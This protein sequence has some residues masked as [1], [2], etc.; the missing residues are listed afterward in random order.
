[1]PLG[2]VSEAGADLSEVI[3]AQFPLWVDLGIRSDRVLFGGYFQYGPALLGS[4]FNDLCEDAEEKAES[5]GPGNDVSCSGRDIRLGLQLQHHFG[6]PGKPDPW[7]GVGVGY[8]WLR[9]EIS[10]EETGVET[11]VK[12]GLHGVEFL[13]LQGGID[14]PLSDSLGLGPFIAFTLGRYDTATR[15]CSGA[16][17][18]L[19]A[20]GGEL[21]EK[22]FHHWLFLG[23]H[24]SLLP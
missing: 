5:A 14:F 3:S 15:D 20:E 13:N 17:G 4:A 6:Q 12:S 9:L 1:M 2:K 16:C 19:D 7:L 23:A 22:A 8:E 11:S 18:D 10:G 21:E 24:L